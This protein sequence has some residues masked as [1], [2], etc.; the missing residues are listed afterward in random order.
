M[1]WP[2]AGAAAPEEIEMSWPIR[3]L[4]L[5]A[6]LVL[7]SACGSK[8][9]PKPVAKPAE[10]TVFAAASTTEVIAEAAKRYEQAHATHVTTSFGSSSTLAKQIKEGAGADVFVSA[11]ED[12][13]DDLAKAGAIQVDTR[14]DL[15]A[16]SLVLVAPKGKGFSVKVSKEFDFAGALPSVKRIAV[17]DPEHVPAGIF[18]RQS[19]EALGWWEGLKDRMAPTLDVRAALRLVE[20]GEADAGIV[21]STDARASEKVEVVA[22][23]PEETHKPIR[24]PVAACSK[25]GPEARK[26]VEFLRSEGM[27]AVYKEHGFGVP[28]SR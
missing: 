24:Y 20:M 9:T 25:A 23:F 22:E 14:V 15:L 28:P 1:R 27:S 12:W 26:F 2:V 18:S 17:A 19:L 11:D 8:A 13:M 16:N 10:L 6:A 21:Y 3:V 5:L 4:S 7:V